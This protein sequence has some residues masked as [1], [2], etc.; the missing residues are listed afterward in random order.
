MDN[1]DKQNTI[2]F[3]I[4]LIIVLS[5]ISLVFACQSKD[6]PE[7]AEIPGQATSSQTLDS[8]STGPSDTMPDDSVPVSSPDEK[9]PVD[10]TPSL[11]VSFG[12]V[13]LVLESLN[14]VDIIRVAAGGKEGIT[15]QYEWTKNGEP[16]GNSDSISGFKRGD[17]IAVKIT[18]FEGKEP[19]QAKILTTE[20]KNSPPKV[21]ENKKAAFDGKL[22]TYQV[23]AT[24]PDG[25]ELSYAL[26]DAPQGMVIDKS[27]GI[28]KWTVP[29]EMQGKQSIKVK[30]SD[31]HGGETLYTLNA[32]ISAPPKK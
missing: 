23:K 5:A 7:T 8:Q 21:V 32:D 9:K 20:I 19:G 31:G 18:P 11:P 10:I 12:K 15:F 6:Q 30:I 4:L 29:K 28:V 16:A 24:D 14:N 13:K 17:K 1:M 27:T 3:Y 22:L 2:N 25:D 26:E